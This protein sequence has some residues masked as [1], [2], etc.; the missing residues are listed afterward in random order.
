MINRLRFGATA[1]V[2]VAALTLTACQAG[3]P[4]SAEKPAECDGVSLTKVGYSPYSNTGGYFPFVER[5]LK[6]AFEPCGIAVTTS[7]PDADSGKQVSGIENLVAAGAKAVVITPTDPKAVSPVAKRLT[8]QGVL[9]VG[10]AT[11][12]PEA[13]ITFNLDDRAFGMIEGTSAGTWLEENRPEEKPKVAILHQ[14]SG[15][16]PLLDRHQGAID[17]IDE[18]LGQGNWELV[19]EVEAFQEDT[20]NAQTSVILQAH[21]DLDLIIGLNDSSALGAVSAIKS[22]GRTPGKDVG[23][24]TGGEDKRILEYVLS[25]EVASTVGLFPVKQGNIIAETILKKSRGESVEREQIVPAELVTSENAQSI[26]DSL[27]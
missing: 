23:V 3:G 25:G 19:S 15:G 5:G 22:S 18:V 24:V 13:D 21:P 7:D 1:L 9:V 6:E 12:I 2:A 26:L 27:S 8:E 10:L 20:G 4:A 11:S 17:G 16:E 14:D